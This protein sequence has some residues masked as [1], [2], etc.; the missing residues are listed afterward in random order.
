[1][2]CFQDKFDTVN[3]TLS[4]SHINLFASDCFGLLLGPQSPS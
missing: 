2:L 4:S 3:T 1:M